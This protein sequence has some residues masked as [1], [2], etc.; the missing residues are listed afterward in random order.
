[1][2]K[3]IIEGGAGVG[4]FERYETVWRLVRGGVL[5]WNSNLQLVLIGTNCSF[6]VKIISR[7]VRFSIIGIRKI[8]FLPK[9]EKERVAKKET[10]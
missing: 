6:H 10:K 7:M 3:I 4:A 5:H 2:F 1:M 8:A 9:F